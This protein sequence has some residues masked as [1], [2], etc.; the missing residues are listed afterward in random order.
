M[1]A[2]ETPPS[3]PAWPLCSG[4]GHLPPEQSTH[5]HMASLSRQSG[6]RATPLGL[7]TLPHSTAATLLAGNEAWCSTRGHQR[8]PNPCFPPIPPLE[9]HQCSR[10]CQ[11]RLRTTDP[12]KT[13]FP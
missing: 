2:R 8:R 7:A 9:L 4:V 11:H 1:L 3:V 10:I 5:G 6:M 12:Q 13:H